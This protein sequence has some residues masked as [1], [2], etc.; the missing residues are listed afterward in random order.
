MPETSDAFCPG[1]WDE[2]NLNLA[3]GYVYACCKATPTKFN[4]DFKT[5][6]KQQ[7]DNLATGIRDASCSSC[8]KLEATGGI[9]QRSI[10]LNNMTHDRRDYVNGLVSPKLLEIN[11]G[12]ECNFQCMYCNPKFSSQWQTDVGNKR[13]PVF[14]DRFFYG[15]DERNQVDVSDENLG[16]IRSLGK[17]PRLSIIGG[18]PLMNK[19]LKAILEESQS[20]SLLITTN[21][22]CKTSTLNQLFSACSK[23]DQVVL[24]VSVDA[25]R[26]ISEFV[27]H[28]QDYSQFQE[29]L[30][31]VLDS[32]PANFQVAIASL[33]TS[34]TVRDLPEFMWEVRG[35]Q[36]QRP[37]T[38]WEVNYCENPRIQSMETLPDKFKYSTL[39]AIDQIMTWSDVTGWPVVRSV[40][41]SSSY[42]NTLARELGAFTQEFCRRKNKTIPK[43]LED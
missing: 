16:V 6:L 27:R 26:E 20:S 23:F 14:T 29:N 40:I 36:Q 17:I 38:T 15:I 19:N 5:V 32:S 12:N 8:W 18:E 25:C 13:Y 30:A 43:C 3:Y 37:G 35:Y 24:A 42:N 11:L 41:E 7:Q 39:L 28:G 33:M 21:L 34:Y 31:H 1:K 2:I 22:S 9:S 4:G 10:Y